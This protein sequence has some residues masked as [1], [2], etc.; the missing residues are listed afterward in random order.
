MQDELVAVALAAA[1]VSRSVTMSYFRTPGLDTR[2]KDEGGFDPVTLAD[3]RAEAAIRRLL[4]ERRPQDAIRGEE[5][6]DREGSSG[7]TWVLD[8]IDGTRGF[9]S[10]TPTWG[11][12]ISLRDETGPVFGLIDQPFTDERFIGGFG[13]AELIRPVGRSPLAVRPAAR[14]DQSILFSTFPEVGTG[15]EREAFLALS[16][17]ARLTRYGMDCY[18]YALLALG[19]VDL[20]V[21]AGLHAFDIQAPIAVIQAAGGIVTDWKGNPAHEGG[22]VVAAASPQL[23]E[24]A[25]QVLS[26]A[27]EN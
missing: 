16:Q 18:A 8:P 5:Y 14:L 12:L 25:L 22:R 26:C 2:N 27:R 13:R 3:R 1:D 20:V 24:E 10:G 23:H 9:I 21:E 11:T 15:T 6:P 19:T 4:E 7:L 17:K